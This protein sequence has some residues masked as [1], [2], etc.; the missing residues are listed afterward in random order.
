MDFQQSVKTIEIPM[1]SRDTALQMA[2]SIEH[3]TETCH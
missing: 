3:L 2:T 1:S